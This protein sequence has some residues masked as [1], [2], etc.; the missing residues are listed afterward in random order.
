MGFGSDEE[1]L[2]MKE[3]F[4]QGNALTLAQLQKRFQR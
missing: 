3:F 1:S 4:R 2:K